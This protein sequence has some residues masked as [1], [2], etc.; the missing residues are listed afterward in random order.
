MTLVLGKLS[1][2]NEFRLWENYSEV[3]PSTTAGP[4]SYVACL[5]PGR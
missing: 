5:S 2:G 1:L 3:S 4:S